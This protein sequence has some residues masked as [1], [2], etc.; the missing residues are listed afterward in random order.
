MLGWA[1]FLD[2]LLEAAAVGEEVF[3]VLL[4]E[5]V[6]QAEVTADSG[7]PPSF[8]LDTNAGKSSSWKALVERAAAG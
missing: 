4:V 1:A 8:R 3:G 5:E 7:L 2:T 6:A